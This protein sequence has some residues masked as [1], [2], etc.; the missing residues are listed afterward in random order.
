MNKKEREKYRKEVGDVMEN[1]L[2]KLHMQGW[3]LFV[4]LPED[5]GW[6]APSKDGFA[7]LVEHPYKLIKLF[8][9]EWQLN[10]KIPLQ[11]RD[12]DLLHEAMHVVLW[13]YTLEA[14]NR[15]T[16]KE[17]LANAEE[18]LCDHL[19]NVVFSDPSF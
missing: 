4:L 19:K 17:Q 13:D 6:I 3:D 18:R 5:K 2:K 14:E 11:N 16:T 1:W 8:V 15:Y 12:D 10:S 7:T 9:S